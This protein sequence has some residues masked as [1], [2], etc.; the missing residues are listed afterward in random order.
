MGKRKQARQLAQRL[1]SER[2]AAH[3]DARQLAVQ[4]AGGGPYPPVDV[5]T[6]ALV[7]NEGEQPYRA[8]SMH[9]HMG[10]IRTDNRII[11]PNLNREFAV[12]PEPSRRT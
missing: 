10:E 3:H 8:F 11:A 12:W 6:F 2:R 4:I 1:G 9:W 7:P 5:Y